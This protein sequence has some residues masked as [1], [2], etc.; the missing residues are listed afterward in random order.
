M[1]KE[2]IIIA[3]DQGI[4]ALNT[5]KA[6]FGEEQRPS[7][8]VIE[9]QN[10][11]LG[12]AMD[13]VAP[14]SFEVEVVPEPKKR[15]RKPK[16]E[17]TPVGVVDQPEAAKEQNIEVM[18]ADE[19]NQIDMFQDLLPEVK[20]E[21]PTSAAST[22]NEDDVR[23]KIVSYAHKHGA[24]KAYKLISDYGSNKLGDL[25]KAKMNELGTYLVGSGF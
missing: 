23:K 21:A 22:F 4:Q 3:I 12:D 2:L 9:E 13:E 1:D 16:A 10:T 15:G 25:T 5:L 6:A 8:I 18:K 20:A 7:K 11:L 17:G 24:E 14:E 19:A